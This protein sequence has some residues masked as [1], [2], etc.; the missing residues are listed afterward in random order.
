MG[1]GWSSGGIRPISGAFESEVE[2][3]EDDVVFVLDGVASS[4]LVSVMVQNKFLYF[5]FHFT[6]L[7]SI[8]FVSI[9][10]DHFF[11][12][13]LISC[14]LFSVT[15][16]TQTHKLSERVFLYF[17]C[18]LVFL[19]SNSSFS[20]KSLSFTTG[21][22]ARFESENEEENERRL[23]CG[24]RDESDKKVKNWAAWWKNSLLRHRN[25]R[26]VQGMSVWRQFGPLSACLCLTDVCV[27]N[28]T[29]F[30]SRDGFFRGEEIEL[31]YFESS[32]RN[33]V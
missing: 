9:F 6:F 3:S 21:R 24:C 8:L 14:V 30:L 18:L 5:H 29:L 27:A 13:T 28:E 15:H 25:R 23:S 33:R 16:L 32:K 1:G 17:H 31:F 11:C 20:K 22:G 12:S 19:L 2:T 7:F 10:L 26:P 4:S